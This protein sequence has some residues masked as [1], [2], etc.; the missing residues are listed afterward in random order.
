M[1]TVLN[2]FLGFQ[3]VIIGISNIGYNRKK[4][5]YS[6]KKGIFTAENSSRNTFFFILFF[7]LLSLFIFSGFFMLVGTEEISIGLVIVGFIIHPFFGIIGFRK[8]LWLTNGM[9]ILTINDTHLTVEKTGTFWVKTKKYSLPKIKNIKTKYE[10]NEFLSNKE[11]I[12]KNILLIKETQRIFTRFTIG[13]IQFEYNGKKIQLFN[14]L[15]N[16]ERNIIT[17]ELKKITT[18]NTV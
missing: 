13:E 18:Y 5:N 10:T 17:K 7:G 4:F 12:A 3:R 2:L 11:N 6:T 8:L 14:E 16:N 15:N 1:N 9:E